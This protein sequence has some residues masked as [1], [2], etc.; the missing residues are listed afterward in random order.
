MRKT[1]SNLASGLTAICL[2]GCAEPPELPV[3]RVDTIYHDAVIWTGVEDAR[4][5]SVLAVNDGRIIFVGQQLPEHFQADYVQDVQGRFLMPGF[6]DNHVHFME[7][8][9]AL[10]GVNLRTADSPSAFI[11][12]IEEYSENLPSGRWVLNGNWD[13]Q[14]WGGA[15]PHRD[16]ID[17]AT[18][19]TPV[20]VIRTDGHMALAN[21]VAL[22]FANITQST[23]DPAGGKIE[24]DENGMPTGILRGNALN[25][26][27]EV[28]PPPEEDELMDQFVAAQDHALRLGLVKVHALTAYPTETTMLEIFKT[29]Q[30]RGLM[31][32]RAFVSTPIESR[33][34]LADEVARTGRGNPQLKW[35]GVKGFIDGSLG[36]RTAWMHQ[37]YSDQPGNFGAPL[38]EIEHLTVW[39]READEDGLE[40][41][42]HALGDRGIDAVIAAMR[43]IGGDDVRARRFRMEHFQHPNEEAINALAELGIIASMQPYHA[44]DDGRWAGPRLGPDRLETTYAFRSVLDAG[45]ILTFGS[46][47]PVA[48]LSPLE[49]VYA[50]V[51]R[52]TLDELN[53]SGWLPD[54]KISVEEALTAYTKSN[55]YAFSEE[56][57]SGTI[58][59]GK[60]A[61]LVILSADPRKT[62]PSMIREIEVLETVIDG[63]SVYVR[64][65]DGRQ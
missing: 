14:K 43:D 51:T 45:G 42:I 62:D 28:I 56:S 18:P 31:K 48:P 41:S 50:A 8:G 15:L 37:P 40:L 16:W 17:A 26:V 27:L 39:M 63:A 32:I 9:A 13:H 49:G 36:A 1:I 38:N 57:D 5:A 25:L 2:S 4:D 61:D 19:S 54:Q 7:G 12:A 44:I 10:S 20:Y 24:R 23:P 59:V 60:R 64:Y 34:D 53:P 11:R 33:N 58:E 29:A 35:G 52:R 21:S 55:A 46:D 65:D 3:E 6:M 30:A 22:Q 47:W